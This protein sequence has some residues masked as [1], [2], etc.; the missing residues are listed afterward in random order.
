MPQL[1]V[2]T[3][4]SQIFWLLTCFLVLFLGV[5]FFVTPKIQSI[6]DARHDRQENNRRRA[7]ELAEETQQLLE[8]TASHI[9]KAREEASQTLRSMEEQLKKTKE[10]KLRDLQKKLDK[11]TS[12]AESELEACRQELNQEIAEVVK[13][14]SASALGAFGVKASAKNLEKA[15]QENSRVQ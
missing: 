7:Q 15:V 9:A 6:L 13:T 10:T 3:Y 14:V 2:S 4:P 1:D 12:E 11:M 5:K 8:A